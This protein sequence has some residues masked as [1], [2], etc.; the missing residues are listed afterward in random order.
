MRVIAV[1]GGCCCVGKEGGHLQQLWN[2][3]TC[4]SH[5]CGVR[6][7]S[8]VVVLVLVLALCAGGEARLGGGVFFGSA[9]V[10]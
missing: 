3:D 7:N 5:V 4:K 1:V 6:L 2:S 10:V 9:F 8:L